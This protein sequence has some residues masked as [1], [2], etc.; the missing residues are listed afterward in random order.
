MAEKIF[1]Q[2]VTLTCARD[3][4]KDMDYTDNR[5]DYVGKSGFL[6]VETEDDGAGHHMIFY[7]LDRHENIA[8]IEAK[9][10]Q[11]AEMEGNSSMMMVTA[12]SIYTFIKTYDLTED[13]EE[14]IF[15]SIQDK[16]QS[17]P[18]F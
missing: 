9:H 17:N 16:L 3:K 5:A 14:L 18:E 10:G 13:E 2:F 4:K 8:K 7:V 6:F 12:R 15:D 1:T 11:F